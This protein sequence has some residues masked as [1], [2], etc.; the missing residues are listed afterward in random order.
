MR[1]RLRLN[2]KTGIML[3]MLG[4]VLTPYVFR[5]RYIP[6]LV[7][8]FNAISIAGALL[9]VRSGAWRRINGR[10]VV[11]LI[12]T[13]VSIGLFLINFSD[14]RNILKTALSIY[15]PL[16]IL[17]L[18]P[19]E[20]KRFQKYF[21]L[22]L[23]CWDCMIGV[24][25]IC[26]VLDM[27]FGQ[28]M[29]RFFSGLY[30]ARSLN[31]LLREGRLVSYIGHSLLTVECALVYLILHAF[32]EMYV[33]KRRRLLIPVI[34]SAIIIAMTGSKTGLLLLGIL[35]IICYGNVKMVKY[36]PVVCVCLLLAYKTGIFDT[37]IERFLRGLRTGDI[38]TGRF[39][40]I[41]QLMGNGTLEFGWISGHSAELMN[42]NARMIAALENPLM[43][44]A[45][46]YGILYAL[47]MAIRIFAIP[48][49][50]M[51]KYGGSR[52]LLMALVYIADI[53][54]YDAVCSIGDGM[55]RY[56]TLIFIMLNMMNYIQGEKR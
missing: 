43:R 38:T 7:S 40:S 37:T 44:W 33:T 32:N 54:T 34:V 47:M 39:S 8:G 25:L 41:V 30:G 17:S 9:L 26:A 42:S 27:V 15:L 6:D 23:R 51:L 53:N 56:C 31:G 29:S 52:I 18:R 5:N 21:P 10:M 3:L 13:V 45:F 48:V 50:R 19:F 11:E 49:Y 2:E 28:V 12:V 14:A 4:I 22:I 20:K 55:L 36:I 46:R 16:I 35:L 1:I 24:V